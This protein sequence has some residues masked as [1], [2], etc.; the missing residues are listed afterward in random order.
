LITEYAFGVS[1]NWLDAKKFNKDFFEFVSQQ[2]YAFIWRHR[3]ARS[4]SLTISCH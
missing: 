2:S 3:E 4:R 1:Y